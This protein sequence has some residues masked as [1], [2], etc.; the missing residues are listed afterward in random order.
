[1][2]LEPIA[3]HDD[4]D[5]A[6]SSTLNHRRRQR[7]STMSLKRPQPRLRYPRPDRRVPPAG[8]W[9]RH[10]HGPRWPVRPQAQLGSSHPHPP[11]RP[12]SLLAPATRYPRLAHSALAPR[13]PRGI[14]VETR[15]AGRNMALG[16]ACRSRLMASISSATSAPIQDNA[17]SSPWCPWG[18]APCAYTSP[19][20]MWQACP[21]N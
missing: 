15:A 20:V 9:Q 17:S 14:A 11:G 8:G 5:G 10:A 12:G 13:C 2:H 21:T 4:T 19:D 7:H 18:L 6:S 1:V 3:H 16:R